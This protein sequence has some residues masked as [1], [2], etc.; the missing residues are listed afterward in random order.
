MWNLTS[1]GVHSAADARKLTAACVR[2]LQMDMKE[3]PGAM[4][5]LGKV[6]LLRI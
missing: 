3:K 5:G 6:R 1:L 4:R 2:V